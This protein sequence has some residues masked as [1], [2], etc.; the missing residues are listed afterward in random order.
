MIHHT[1]LRA[2]GFTLALF[3]ATGLLSPA[4][5]QSRE[6][7]AKA[8]A[9]PAKTKEVPKAPDQPRVK[10]VYRGRTVVASSTLGEAGAG[11]NESDAMTKAYEARREQKYDEARRYYT[12]AAE[13]GNVDAMWVL[14]ILYENGQG[15]KQ[16]YVQARAWYQKAADAGNAF[17]K[18]QLELIKDK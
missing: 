5:A 8:T 12:R 4:A 10:V 16:D 3:V 2:A 14:G 6:V 13:L 7:M 1:L 15:V 17:A 9:A 18:Q 11:L